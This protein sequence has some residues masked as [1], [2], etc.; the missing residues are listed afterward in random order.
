V[1]VGTIPTAISV[2]DIMTGTRLFTDPPPHEFKKVGA[3]GGWPA[4]Q[5]SP[6]GSLAVHPMGQAVFEVGAQPS[7][8]RRLWEWKDEYSQVTDIDWNGRI[9]LEE[10]RARTFPRRQLDWLLAT[11][12]RA[13]ERSGFADHYCVRDL[14]TG[15]ILYRCDEP[16][17]GAQMTVRDDGSVVRIDP[18]PRWGLIAL[19]QAILAAPL[20]ALWSLL[21]WRSWRMAKATR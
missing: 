5:I 14:R 17:L 3:S 16:S 21:R 8:H 2:F 9:E 20:L 6:D 1:H 18:T 11:L 10:Q 13:P 19:L 4:P 12:I 15:A 7:G